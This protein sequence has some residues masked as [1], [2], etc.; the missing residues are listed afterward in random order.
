MEVKE[1]YK[2]ITNINKRRIMVLYDHVNVEDLDEIT[3]EDYD[4]VFVSYNE[5]YSTNLAIIWG[6][7]PMLNSKS[8]LKPLFLDTRFEERFIRLKDVID[9][10]AISP[11]DESMNT[12][13]EIIEDKITLS[14]ISRKRDKVNNPED[15]FINLCRFCISRGITTMSNV[16]IKG[17]AKG[18]MGLL[19]VLFGENDYIDSRIFFQQK[20]MD[21]KFIR[22]KRFV[23]RVYLCPV[24]S[25][26]HLLFVECCPKCDSS[27]IH[28]EPVIHHF[29]CANISPESTYYF[30][31]E[32]RCPKC[33]RFLHHIG[34]DYDTPASVY[35]CDMCSNTFINSTMRVECTKCGHS[36]TP[37]KLVPYDIKEYEFTELGIRAISTDAVKLSVTKNVLV[38]YSGYN[39]FQ[40]T[41]RLIDLAN[42][43]DNEEVVLVVRATMPMLD[44]GFDENERRALVQSLV[45]QLP[46]CKLSTNGRYLYVMQS[47]PEDFYEDTAHQ[48][49]TAI[50]DCIISLNLLVN[51][52]IEVY[53]HRKG[54]SIS[55]FIRSIS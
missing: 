10:W 55:E 37:E 30:D 32:L 9:G 48:I 52:D 4:A 38:G 17:Y 35:T 12:R 39:E 27:K 3:Y 51:D 31:G 53:V 46:F 7:L 42:S 5:S 16:T 22:E 33:K 21:L 23:D 18:Y 1:K 26:S 34:V 2:F 54:E 20:L 49:K 40:E 41:M 43:K 24:C 11:Y 15:L 29:R 25:D 45:L 44:N 50:N 8:W 6:V 28:Q 14:G 13:I 47:N 19:Y 36:S